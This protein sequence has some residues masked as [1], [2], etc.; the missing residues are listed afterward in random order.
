MYAEFH[1]ANRKERDD[2][3]YI[4]YSGGGGGGLNSESPRAYTA[5]EPTGLGVQ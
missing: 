2:L 3:R 4:V 1:I 5:P